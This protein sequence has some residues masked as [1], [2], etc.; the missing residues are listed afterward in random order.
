MNT[1]PLS[2]GPYMYAS[3]GE[4]IRYKN[5]MASVDEDGFCDLCGYRESNKAV[6]KKEA[7]D[8][9]FMALDIDYSNYTDSAG[10]INA[11]KLVENAA[12]NFDKY[13]WLDNDTH[14]VWDLALEVA[15]EGKRR[16]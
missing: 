8:F 6:S 14:W 5:H 10:E 3:P 15:E 2:V 16:K 7:K 1:I 9:M 13:T 4:C 11:T 12:F